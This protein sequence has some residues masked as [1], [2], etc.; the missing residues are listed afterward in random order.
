MRVVAFH[1][2]A[3]EQYNERAVSDKRAENELGVEG[4]GLYFSYEA[5]R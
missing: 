5:H 3:F 2:M 4:T 1:Q